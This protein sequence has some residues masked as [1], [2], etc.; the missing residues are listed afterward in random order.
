MTVVL[1]YPEPTDQARASALAEQWH[2]ELSQQAPTAG[3]ALELSD[4]HLALKNYS[5]EE[6]SAIWVDFVSGALAHRRKYGGGRGQAIAKAIGLKPGITPNVLDATAGLGRDAFVLAT[7]GCEVTLL[8]RSPVLAAMLSDGLA[9][10]TQDN[11]VSDIIA[12]MSLIHSGAHDYL[13]KLSTP[14]D[15]IYLD[16][17]FPHRDKSAKVKKEMSL[18][19]QLL[20]QDED[21]DALLPLALEKAAFRVVVKRPARAPFLNQQKPTLSLK[22]KANRFDIYV[23]RSLEKEWRPADC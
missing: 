19:Q 20:G 23:K 12:R 17:M 10:A 3:L 5:P 8:E 7:L 1:Y 22:G 6:A 15:V 11:E 13:R 14:I 16:P 9:R 21:A 4:G 2:L 18:L